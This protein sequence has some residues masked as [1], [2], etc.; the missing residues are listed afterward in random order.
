[1]RWNEL[2][3]AMLILVCRQ[4]RLIAR[5]RKK[6]GKLHHEQR[7]L[8]TIPGA[9]LLPLGLLV[10]GFCIQYNEAKN[11]YVGACVAMAVGSYCTV[12]K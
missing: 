11:S 9:I 5:S 2:Q 4:D 10:Y 7:L 8:A 12:P 6:T 3:R 1:M